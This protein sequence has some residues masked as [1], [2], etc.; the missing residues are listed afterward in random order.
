MSNN[1]K[2]PTIFAP[3]KS[4]RTFFL[5]ELLQPY[6]GSHPQHFFPE[7]DTFPTI[8]L[9][10]ECLRRLYEL[11]IDNF[12]LHNYP[13]AIFFCDKLLTLS[14]NHVGVIYLMGECY[15]RNGDYKRVHSL[16]EN[17]KMLGHNVSFQLLAARALLLNKHY[18]QCLNVLELQI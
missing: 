11:T 4:Q 18:D 5:A 10:N 15:F 2:K 13:D 3:A 16:F 1:P 12:N 14:N 7:L 8:I 17:Y 9:N 6:Y